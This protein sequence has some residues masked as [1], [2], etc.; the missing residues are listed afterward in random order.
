MIEPTPGTPEPARPYL[1]RGP[2]KFCGEPERGTIGLVN[3]Q[4]VV[5]CVAC[6]RA[7]YNAPRTETGERQRSVT[8]VQNGVK[9]KMRFVVLNRAGRRCELCGEPI[10]LHEGLA[11]D[12]LLSV[13][14]GLAL[15]LTEAQLNHIENL[16]ALCEEC[17]SGK[18]RTTLPLYLTLAIIRARTA[19]QYEP[20]EG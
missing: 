11:V 8:T 17:N 14:D 3:G 6:S 20:S 13:E 5:R 18:G 9:P 12:H 1:M 4:N 2:C 7:V 10:E 19:M 16:A 15:G